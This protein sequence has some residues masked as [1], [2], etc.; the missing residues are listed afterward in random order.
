MYLAY[1]NS[2]SFWLYEWPI[3]NMAAKC[4][5]QKPWGSEQGPQGG[6]LT[7]F[8]ITLREAAGNSTSIFKL[9]K[10]IWFSNITVGTQSLAWILQELKWLI[11]ILKLICGF[12]VV[13]FCSLRGWIGSYW[14]QNDYSLRLS[15]VVH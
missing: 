6:G 4:W 2:S 10:L 13:V 11:W 14:L 5:R 12:F 3:S 15:S 9:R 7:V 1:N 8:S